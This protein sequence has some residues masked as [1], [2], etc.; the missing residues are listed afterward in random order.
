MTH[1]ANGISLFDV[2][3]PAEFSQGH[4]PG[5]KNLPLLNNEERHIVGLTYKER[6]RNEATRIG[7]DLTGKKFANFID[8]A[9]ALAPTRE[10]IVHCWRGGMRSSVMAWLLEM[11]GFKVSVLKGGYKTFRRWALEQLTQP[12]NITILAG[13]TGSGKTEMLKLLAASGECVIDLE[14]LAH[15]RGSTF[16]ALGQLPQPTQEQFENNLALQWNKVKDHA[17]LEDESRWIGRLKIPDKIYELMRASRVL[18]MI[19]SVDYRSER[20]LNEYGNFPV[21]Q[22]KERTSMLAKRLGGDRLK[23][24]L[25]FLDVQDTKGWADIML[26]YY[27]RQYSHGIS[28]RDPA[29]VHQLDCTGQAVAQIARLLIS[30]KNSTKKIAHERSN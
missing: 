4:I 3:S 18:A 1:I 28:L 15:H 2:R 12:K 16:G 6:G 30:E 13:K 11:A 26:D 10:V 20:I 22:L 23:E 24:A 27:D 25:A 19:F 7:F 14:A 17:W 29:L 8:E 5:A 21:D 9:H